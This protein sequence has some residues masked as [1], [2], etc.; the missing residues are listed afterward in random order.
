MG[1]AYYQKKFKKLQQHRFTKLEKN[2][3]IY[4]SRATR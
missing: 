1:S 4:M 2:Y 3:I